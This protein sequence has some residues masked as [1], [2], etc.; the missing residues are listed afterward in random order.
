M[1]SIIILGKEIPYV[2][3]R[4]DIHDLHFYEENPRVYSKLQENPFFENADDKQRFVQEQMEKETSVKKLIEEIKRHEGVLEPI[5]VLYPSKVLEGNSRLAALRKL[6][7]DEPYEEKWQTVP[8]RLI[9]NLEQKEIDAYLHQ[10][11]VEGK[12]EWTPYEKAY[13]TYKRVEQ[14]EV[15]IEEYMERTGETEKA[16][17]KQIKTI[18]L[19]KENNERERER[20]SYYDVLVTNKIIKE[21]FEDNSEFKKFILSKIKQ[22]KEEDEEFTATEMRKKLP[23]VLAKSKIL[24]KFIAGEE[25]LEDA[26]LKAKTSNALKD[27]R[28]AHG[29]LKKIDKKALAN[30]ERSGLGAVEQE[31]RRCKKETDRLEKLIKNVKT[32]NMNARRG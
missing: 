8:C 20:W 4:K 13:K 12:T 30:L 3:E 6:N 32:A 23:V 15:S 27:A 26:Y 29:Y 11:H 14:D 2:S 22:Q 7:R 18:K 10:I 21:H 16:I 19:M 17:K 28:N 5:V 31:V 24:N 25:T 9:N 1:T